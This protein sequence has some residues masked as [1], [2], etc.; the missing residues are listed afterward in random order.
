MDWRTWSPFQSKKIREICEHLTETEKEEWLRLAASWGRWGAYSF[1]GPIGLLAG[2]WVMA[3]LAV[4]LEFPYPFPFEITS[5]VAISVI[6]ILLVILM[7]A[8]IRFRKNQ[9]EFLASTEWARS[10]GYTADE[11]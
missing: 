4:R 2:L 9:K 10:Q 7:P 6:A 5:R 8:A 1:A 11:L 3:R